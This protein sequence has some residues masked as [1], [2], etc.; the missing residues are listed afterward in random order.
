[1]HL[2]GD[3]STAC[4]LLPQGK[5]EVNMTPVES[6][7]LPNE[8]V[9]VLGFAARVGA[10]LAD[11]LI[12]C[13]GSN[14][15]ALRSSIDSWLEHGQ[16]RAE[17][18]GEL[19]VATGPGLR[20]VDQARLGPCEVKRS[21]VLDLIVHA[22]LTME[23]EM[24]SYPVIGLRDIRAR[25]RAGC[26]LPRA[27]LR[28]P[29]G[30]KVGYIPKHLLWAPDSR[31]KRPIALEAELLRKLSFSRLREVLLG[32]H[33]CE[34]VM[35]VIYYAPIDVVIGLKRVVQSLS[36]NNRVAER[37]DF[38]SAVKAVRSGKRI[39]IV[40]ESRKSV[41][42]RDAACRLIGDFGR[43]D[44]AMIGYRA[45]A[46]AIQHGLPEVGL[47]MSARK[48]HELIARILHWALDG[49]LVPSRGSDAAISYW[50]TVAA[51]AVELRRLRA[52]TR[53]R[54]PADTAE[55]ILTLPLEE[56]SI[57]SSTHV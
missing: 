44:D 27:V 11:D 38:D 8:K 12:E 47:V 57:H 9:D 45:A 50:K 28:T 51:L 43:H 29:G 35:G 46:Q 10:F 4:L 17:L 54:S 41:E 19:L 14:S 49:Q 22:R 36:L 31:D 7:L 53:G 52:D 30:F 2:S 55:R 24:L 42:H 21:N 40:P 32:L 34:E 6:I 13:V 3:L 16:L 48:A 39:V 33:R 37:H 15:S 18:G 23:L 5:G 20:R 25:E 26:S 1:V 56:A